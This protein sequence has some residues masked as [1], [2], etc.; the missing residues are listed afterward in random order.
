MQRNTLEHVKMYHRYIANDVCDAPATE[1]DFGFCQQY[2]EF[3]RGHPSEYYPST[4][5]LNF[6]VQMRNGNFNTL[7]AFVSK[8]TNIFIMENICFVTYQ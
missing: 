3:S 6:S 4:M 8:L 1:C 7:N 2:Q 5:L